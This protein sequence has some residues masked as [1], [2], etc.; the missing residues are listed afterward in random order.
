[1]KCVHV[2]WSRVEGLGTCRDAVI[3]RRLGVTHQAVQ[4]ARVRL[5][6]ST[7][8]TRGRPPMEEVTDE[9]GLVDGYQPPGPG[10]PKPRS[11]VRWDDV[12]DLGRVPDA[13]LA[14]RLGVSRD[15]VKNAR[16]RRVPR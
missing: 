15:A 5:G 7:K 16:R 1:M 14:D 8:W 13:V 10:V 11:G 4:K 2:D 3:A 12:A 9:P 6:I